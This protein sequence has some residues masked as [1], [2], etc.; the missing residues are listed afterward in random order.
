[1]NKILTSS[2]YLCVLGNGLSLSIRPFPGDVRDWA[3][4]DPVVLVGN[5]LGESREIFLLQPIE[6]F[7]LIRRGR[8]VEK[9]RLLLVERKT[10]LHLNQ[11]EE[12]LQSLMKGPRL[13][14]EIH[15]KAMSDPHSVFLVSE[16]S[17][18][19]SLWRT[20][21]ASHLS[22]SPLAL[23]TVRE[24]RP[25]S[26]K[27]YRPQLGGLQRSFL[28]SLKQY[29]I[30]PWVGC[31]VFQRSPTTIAAG[32]EGGVRRVGILLRARTRTGAGARVRPRSLTRSVRRAGLPLMLA[33]RCA[34]IEC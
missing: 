22:L 10:E 7:E 32:A 15:L 11:L 24:H 30:L 9:R 17:E 5:A 13:A 14:H 27:H 3:V 25:R 34:R 1:L 26:N 19:Q 4:E 28:L 33:A 16:D 21:W 20:R 31:Q 18:S 12:L 29:S 23:G 6:K 2:R 8:T